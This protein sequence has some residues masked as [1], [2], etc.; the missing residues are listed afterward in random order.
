MPT[1]KTA[2]EKLAETIGGT[3]GGSPV[4]ETVKTAPKVVQSKKSE[5]TAPETRP[6]QAELGAGQAQVIA[7]LVAQGYSYTDALAMLSGGDVRPSPAAASP[8]LTKEERAEIK[9]LSEGDD[10]HLPP[11]EDVADKFD[12]VEVS[13]ERREGFKTLIDDLWTRREDLENVSKKTR[14]RVTLDIELPEFDWLLHRTIQEGQARRDTEFS[15]GRALTLLLKQQKALDPTRGGKRQGG[16]TG[17]RQNF[18]PKNG[19]WTG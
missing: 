9:R 8:A 1:K 17:L 15:V 14:F 5:K 12:V 11:V 7:A 2:S 18:D 16:A 10:S 19:G 4:G 3:G 6:A 13:L